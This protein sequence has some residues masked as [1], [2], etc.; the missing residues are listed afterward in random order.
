MVLVRNVSSSGVDSPASVVITTDMS[1]TT[2]GKGTIIHCRPPADTG[3]LFILD[4]SK[5]PCPSPRTE[6]N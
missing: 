3:T 4:S 5:V 2:S 1:L 6:L